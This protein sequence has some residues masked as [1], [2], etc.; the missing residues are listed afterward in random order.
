M[1]NTNFEMVLESKIHG[2]IRL[3]LFLKDDESSEN[4]YLPPLR[5]KRVY[6]DNFYTIYVKCPRDIMI[7]ESLYI[8]DE[9]VRSTFKETR[10][11]CFECKCGTV[12]REC[13]GVVKIELDIDGITYVTE[14]IP[15]MVRNGSIDQ[16]VKNMIDYIYA[17]CENYLYEEHKYSKVIAGIKQAPEISIEARL[18]MLEKVLSTYKKCYAFFR[19]AP[20]TKLVNKEITGDFEKLHS[21]TPST[22]TYIITHPDLLR[23]VNYNSGIYYNQHYYQPDKTLITSTTYSQDIYENQ[24]VIGFIK[25]IIS[26][27]HLMS[28][29]IIRHIYD[30]PQVHIENEY[31]ESTYY[32][33]TRSEK[34][35]SEYQNKVQKL[36]RE[37]EKLY[38]NYKRILTVSE[39]IFTGKPRLTNIFK[40]IMP[41]RLIYQQIL[42]WYQCGNYNFA[43]TDLVL[44]FI[45]LS[46]IYEYYCLLKLNVNLEKTFGFTRIASYTNKYDGISQQY[47]RNTKYNNTF[48][49]KSGDTRL[50]V[51]YQPVVYGQVSNKKR[52]NIMLYR[53]TTISISYKLYNC[54]QSDND[55]NDKKN[56]GTFY[57]PDFIIKTEND[58]KSRYY[59]FDA[60]FS[61]LK[62]VK[63]YQLPLLIYKYFFSISTLNKSDS[64]D[65]LCFICGK[66]DNNNAYINVY[67]IADKLNQEMGQFVYLISLSGNIV[68]ND[69]SI[70]KL[71]DKCI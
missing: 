67:D 56:T 47:Y 60:K 27:L 62:N 23:S 18:E 71:L 43:K 48:V 61:T 69:D 65:G 8:N 5:N 34:A 31:V 29:D 63:E 21:I 51:Y 42:K 2:A 17:N 11:N 32:I 64:I 50:I 45:T 7:I 40:T 13:F 16:S 55:D 9:P 38:Q 10:K 33:Y 57:T 30:I 68:D 44:S 52:N 26:E 22:I 41:Y 12:F 39:F 66:V 59:I 49:Y 25:K 24:V 1:D 37:F 54:I 6:N 36:L 15:V 20:Y 3:P 4:D 53:N 35:L 19:N 14:N 58:G 70:V 46:K 28:K